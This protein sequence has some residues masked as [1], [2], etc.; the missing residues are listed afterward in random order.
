M[1]PIKKA[2]LLHDLCGVGKAALTNM[3]PILGVMGVEACP[4]P[5]MLL[6]THTGGYGIPAVSHIAPEY[7]RNCADHYKREQI[8]FDAIFVGYIGEVDTIDAVAYFLRQF[9]DVTVIFDPIMGDHGKY[10]SNFDDSYLN[11]L[12]KLLPY[13]DIL[14]PNFTEFCFLSGLSF[15]DMYTEE[16]VQSAALQ[17]GLKETAQIVITSVPGKHSEKNI[18]IYRKDEL[19]IQHLSAL[20]Y[21]FHGSGD[22]FDGVFLGEYLRGHS[23]ADAVRTAHHFVY[24]CILA[25]VKEDYPKRE[26]LMIEKSL[27]ILV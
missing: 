4:I 21:E 12:K 13:A 25:S 14:L 18:L 19:N 11:A 3:L 8:D 27:G 23:I 22:A 5:T 16:A 24:R 17:F 9:P 2:V 10:Y 26:G 1:K 7:I 20:P 6:S 15:G